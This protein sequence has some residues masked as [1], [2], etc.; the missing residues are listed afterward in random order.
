MSDADHR[1]DDAVTAARQAAL[2]KA[3]AELG[4]D[5]VEVVTLGGNVEREF[6]SRC[7]RDRIEI[8]S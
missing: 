7:A 1:E 2:D 3:C 6:C 4:H 8:E 5:Y